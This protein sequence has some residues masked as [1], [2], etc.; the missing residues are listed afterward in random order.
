[1]SPFGSDTG[2]NSDHDGKP[3]CDEEEPEVE[4]VA[5]VV[6]RRHQD[7]THTDLQRGIIINTLFE[8][9]YTCS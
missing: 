4:D 7:E 6:G 5:E 3:T 1:M 9:R 2:D 8:I